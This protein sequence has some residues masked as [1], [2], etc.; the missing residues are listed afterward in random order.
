MSAPLRLRT[1]S[2]TPTLRGG[3]HAE[4]GGTQDPIAGWLD[5]LT[6]M[7]PAR[8]GA[9]IREDLEEHVR[10]RVRDLVLAGQSDAA[11][12]RTAIA[13][14]GDAAAV[15]QRFREAAR[16]PF[17]RLAMNFAVL[18]VAGAALVTSL[19]GVMRPGTG[20]GG[21]VYQP[22][23][24]DRFPGGKEPGAPVLDLKEG[25]L[26]DALA[27][28]A[29]FADAAPMV[30]WSSLGESGLEPDSL[31][32]AHSPAGSLSAAFDVLNDTLAGNAQER[33]IDFRL[34]DGV[35][36]VA[37]P[38]WF[39]QRESTLVRYDLGP[40]EEQGIPLDEFMGLVEQ[41]VSSDDW[42]NNGGTLA[43]YRVVGHFAFVK[44]PPRIHDGVQ[45]F[46]S[47]F[48]EAEQPGDP[49][50]AA[51]QDGGPVRVYHIQHTDA[52][53]LLK[54]LMSMQSI[55]EVDFTPWAADA[56]TNSILGKAPAKHHD[57]VARAIKDL[58]SPEAALKRR[59]GQKNAEMQAV[60]AAL[61]AQCQDDRAR[62]E[63]EIAELA[64]RGVAEDD[65]DAQVLRDRLKEAQQ[66]EAEARARLLMLEQ[67]PD[68]PDRR[69]AADPPPEPTETAE[70]SARERALTDFI[71]ATLE[72]PMEPDAQ[73]S[74]VLR[75]AM[76]QV[77]LEPVVR[78]QTYIAL[79][80]I[81]RLALEPEPITR[82]LLMAHADA[83]A[84]AEALRSVLKGTGES[85]VT[86]E[87][88]AAHNTVILRGPRDGVLAAEEG[89]WKLDHLVG[90]LPRRE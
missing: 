35:L 75:H 67:S 7:L 69:G 21:Q 37:R 87:V 70:A 42:E 54:V 19:V 13:E 14:L 8:Q 48:T 84:V 44:G 79:E 61:L 72:R 27:A 86:I 28:L 17:R 78:A 16:T 23:V 32:T 25:C 68:A 22:I 20:P 88:D 41:F 40:L 83:Q 24:A 63:A 56:R 38:E 36:E 62:I 52:Q 26:E 50:A 82:A 89:A 5:V 10:D 74:D 45:W 77:D 4:R 31:I 2:G 11:A 29:K 46:L 73:L 90:V 59:T 49:G 15:A 1:D 65:P 57:M 58:D 47:Q 34:R 64:A 39:D 33:V 6:R 51:D 81:I 18:S 85:P 53:D 9:D 76:V 71:A 12:T 55:R 43:K 66:R 3:P 30:R 60:T 80:P